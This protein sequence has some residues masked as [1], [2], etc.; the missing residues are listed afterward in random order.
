VGPP[1]EDEG[2]D[3]LTLAEVEVELGINPIVALE[4]HLLNMI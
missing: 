4:K 3:E 1:A 2:E